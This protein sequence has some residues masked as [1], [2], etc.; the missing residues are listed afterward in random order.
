MGK[1]YQKQIDFTSDKVTDIRLL[2]L[3]KND[4]EF[5]GK[6]IGEVQ[7][8]FRSELPGQNFQF[9]R[10]MNAPKGTLVLFQFQGRLIA[11][12]LLKKT[13]S[14]D[15]VNESGYGGY[16][17][18]S[19][20]SI[21]TFEPMDIKDVQKIWNGIKGFNQ[22]HQSLDAEQFP[23]LK[24]A[25][26]KRQFKLMNF[27]NDE[28]YQKAV[29]EVPV[30]KAAIED[31]PKEL[32][33]KTRKASEKVQWSRM[34]LIAKRAIVQADFSCEVDAAHEF[35]ISSVTGE[36]YVEA[37]HLIPLAFQSQFDKSLD[38][39]A[40]IV[41]LCAMCH[42]KIHHAQESEKFP[43]VE[44]LFDKRSERLK[45]CEI[46]IGKEDLKMRY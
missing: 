34:P 17:K 44:V 4:R 3:S 36:N 5:T 32:V 12:A 35:F 9:K 42:K 29:E 43:M 7:E 1:K 38:V 39:E 13:V 21:T 40:N 46:Y 27:K 20:S 24:Q 11:A 23:E 26:E 28:E 16:Y 31:T 30:K 15:E 25:L 2:P 33:E 10:K 6:S 41:S 45:K 18:F 8:W 22:S 19:K 37:H 14:Y